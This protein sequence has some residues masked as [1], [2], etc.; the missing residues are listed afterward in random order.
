MKRQ[1]LH[2]VGAK[3]W[4]ALLA[5][6]CLAGAA[7]G[8]PAAGAAKIAV[9][10]SYEALASKI[11][12]TGSVR[13]IVKVNAPFQPMGRPD[14]PDSKR[15]MNGIATAQ[16]AV[17]SALAKFKPKAYHKYSYTPYL[18]VEAGSPTLQA[19]LAS[20][21]VLEVHED[22]PEFPTL[23][24]SVP[25]IGAP[26]LWN[27]YAPG[28]GFDGSGVTVAILDTGVDKTHPF[29]S[30]AVVSEACYS[31]NSTGVQSLCPGGVTHSTAAGSAMPYASG[32]CPATQCDH[33]THIAGIIA[34][35]QGIATFPP[36]LT[37]LPGGVAPGST[38]IAIQV[39]SLLGGSVVAYKSDT[40]KGLE[41]VYALSSAY[42]ISSV[43]MSLGDGQYFSN[44]DT[45]T[46]K[47]IIDSLKAAGIATVI[48]SG[49][50][51]Y[52]GSMSAPACI[53][54]AVSVGA[55]DASGGVD[56]VVYFSNSAPFLSL[57]APG[58][59]I[60]SSIPGGA[61]QS[62]SGTSMATPHVA[63]AW[64][65][66]KQA[67]P[68]ST[69]DEVLTA[70]SS[71]GTA[72]TDLKCTLVTKK[73]ISVLDAYNFLGTGP[74]AQTE[75][76]TNITQTTATLNGTV[77]ANNNT[78]T[79]VTFDY[80]TTTSYEIASGITADPSPVNGSTLTPVSLGI[81]GLN[82]NTLYHFRVNA[83][84]S[85]GNDMTFTTVGA[86]AT[87][88]AGGFETGSPSVSWSEASV[89]FGT[90]LCTIDI[91]GGA[92]PRT[93]LWWAW[94][95]AVAGT[96]EI[97]S[98]TQDVEIP[99]GSSPRLE[100]YLWKNTSSGNGNDALTV[101]VDGA[102]ILS[103]PEGNTLYGSG[104]VLTGIDLSAYANGASHS[105]SFQSTTTG[106]N[107]T[108]FN[109]DDVSIT[110]GNSTT[111]PLVV[112]EA[113][114]S[115]TATGATLKGTVNANN[116]STAVT[117]DYGTSTSY[118]FTVTA[119]PGTVA[120]SSNTTVSAPLSG[121]TPGMT[122]HYRVAG[123]SVTGKSYGIDM[124]FKPS[125]APD[126]IKI[127]GTPYNSILLAIT[128]AADSDALIQAKAGDFT[129]DLLFE[130]AGTVALEGGYDCAFVS[131]TGF[132]TLTG[133]GGTGGSITIVGSGTVILEN[134]IVQ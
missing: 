64:A 83:G 70:F 103:V 134:I 42:D 58:W 95:G 1:A 41:R 89:N 68:D 29:L 104:Y 37:P 31:T 125:C 126:S 87:I 80:G 127:G 13:L 4:G 113:A 56:G 5:V 34:G 44:C 57:L 40:M 91:C 114:T 10:A 18:F 14:S 74:S 133:P 73:R 118:G 93:G 128:A 54:S 117:F 19:L 90:P 39:H 69:V 75:A 98:L 48:S 24:I 131:K 85:N 61:Y 55:T 110:C 60:N 9:P 105:I 100:F 59:N 65:L 92:G 6:L 27:L 122:Y 35:R 30:G 115:V 101:M 22:I 36:L 53:S 25:L 49:N 108:D 38:I 2:F 32:V 99:S 43:N 107:T 88:A 51:N 12:Q 120:G 84:A 26:T 106:S 132:T 82:E 33:G 119:A 79:A 45:D 123:S 17:L 72:V 97:S 63:G 77:N 112:T 21:L 66:L 62:M 20:P 11:G 129:E 78:D 46:R 86:C 15:Q 47:P 109:V 23:N 116:A 52:C 8:Q 28:Q 71:T 50:D 130:G 94:F 111:L 102:E 16:D 121:L 3:T 67:K 81:T 96:T 7:F 76:A 124:T